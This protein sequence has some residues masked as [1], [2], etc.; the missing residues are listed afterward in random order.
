MTPKLLK[1]LL[2]LI[3]SVILW[4]FVSFSNS[5]TTTFRVPVE[6]TNIKEGYALL[7]QTSSEIGLTIKGE[8]WSL[9]QITFGP[10][11]TFKISTNENIG[12]QNYNVSDAIGENRWLSS[13][14]EVVSISPLEIGYSVER[15]NYKT[16]PIVAD[17]SIGID[18]GFGL[19]SKVELT[20]DSV[21]ISGPKSLIDNIKSVVTEKYEFDNN[22]ESI[23]TQ[24]KL[25]EIKHI[26]FENDIT[27]I[28]FVVQKIVDKTFNNIPI[29]IV[30]VPNL[31]ELN[32]FPAN[33][34]VT[35]RGGLEDLGIQDVESIS[36]VVDFNDA[37]RD[38]LGF[39]KPQITIPEFTTLINVKPNKLKYI[40]KQY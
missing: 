30:N 18:E 13:S 27:N 6:F 15:L 7:S 37:F 31:R 14:I 36:A 32:L 33:I 5:Y 17:I 10:E 22:D 9:A 4:V 29:K 38:T 2:A 16:I 8:G 40:I 35:L 20:P 11:T 34:D 23:S 28:E 3:F 12:I 24:L 26:N 1:I 21:K 39:V 19:V 25:K